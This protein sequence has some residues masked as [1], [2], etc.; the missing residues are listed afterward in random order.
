M[1]LSKDYFKKLLYD[2]EPTEAIFQLS[3][4]W[5]IRA[6]E[7]KKYFGLSLPEYYVQLILI[8][9]GEVF[10]GGHFQYYENRGLK[11]FQNTLKACE[12]ISSIEF[13]NILLQS[14]EFLENITDESYNKWHK[15]DQEL[16]KIS[17]DIEKDIIEF[18]IKDESSVL[19]QERG[20]NV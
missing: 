8:Y 5:S 9:T 15:L 3:N 7:E 20:L 6:N 16:Y 19:I 12:A 2:M 17:D 18:V 14:S 10:N 1:K 11:Y 4:F 13:K